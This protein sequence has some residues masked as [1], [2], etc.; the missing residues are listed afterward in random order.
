[1]NRALKSLQEGDLKLRLKTRYEK[2]ERK[3]SIYIIKQDIRIY[4]F[5]YV[6]FSQTAKLLDRG[7]SWVAVGCY[8]LK[9]P[10]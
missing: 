1:M 7:H 2:L 5:I 9:N 6:A 3:Q 10:I 4:I 8:R